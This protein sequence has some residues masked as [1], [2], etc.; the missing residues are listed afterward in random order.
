MFHLYFNPINL[1][2]YDDPEKYVDHSE[3][4][5]DIGF[6]VTTVPFLEKEKT[7]LIKDMEKMGY[8]YAKFEEAECLHD[9]FPFR[10][11]KFIAFVLGAKKF[12]SKLRQFMINDSSILKGINEGPGFAAFETYSPNEIGFYFPLEKVRQFYL[13]KLTPPGTKDD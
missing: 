1:E 10:W 6:L 3:L 5:A 2:Y 4:R 13:T 7:D 11:P 9:V 8:T 12:Y